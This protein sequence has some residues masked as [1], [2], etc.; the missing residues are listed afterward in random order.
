[1]PRG[2]YQRPSNPA[3]VSGPGKLSRRTDGGPT[4]GAKY[5]GGGKYGESKQLMEQQQ[6]APMSAA[7]RQSAPKP[8]MPSGPA[9]TPLTAPTERPQEPLTTGMP[10]G[11][12]AGPEILNLGQNSQRTSDVIR[13]LIPFDETGQL[14]D[15]YNYLTSRG[16]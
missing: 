8:Q 2:G 12:G 4:Q 13:K 14:S 10:F 7:A 15:F 9:V 3:P 5:M 16:L 11:A 1:M 6:S